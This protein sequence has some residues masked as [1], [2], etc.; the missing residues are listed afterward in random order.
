MT[1]DGIN[2]AGVVCNINVVPTDDIGRTTGT[3]GKDDLCGLCLVRFILDNADNAKDAINKLKTKNIWMPNS[4]GYDLEVHLMVSD[5]TDTF[6]VEFI[7]NK[8][9]VIEG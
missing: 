4:G 3:G 9:V 2:D 5:G 7:K 8:M 1:L 6:V